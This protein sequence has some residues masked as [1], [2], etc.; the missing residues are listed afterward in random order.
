MAGHGCWPTRTALRPAATR[1]RV[2]TS[3][4]SS[5]QRLPPTSLSPFAQGAGC[6]TSQMMD[7]DRVSLRAF[8]QHSAAAVRGAGRLATVAMTDI[9]TRRTSSGLARQTSGHVNRGPRAPEFEIVASCRRPQLVTPVRVGLRCSRVSPLG[10]CLGRA[11]SLPTFSQPRR[12][13]I[14][15]YSRRVPCRRPGVG[16]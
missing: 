3:E 14:A 6:V 5:W 1:C 12:A 16:M 4:A 8:P 9:G 11:E 7:A 10:S 13:E 15:G 2:E